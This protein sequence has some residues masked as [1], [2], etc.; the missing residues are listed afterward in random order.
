MLLFFWKAEDKI[1]QDER[2]RYA[3]LR[4]Q[5][6]QYMTQAEQAMIKS[7]EESMAKLI[8]DR[9]KMKTKKESRTNRGM[10]WERKRERVS[11]A[12]HN[13]GKV[14]NDKIDGKAYSRPVQ[15]KGERKE[16]VRARER[17]RASKWQSQ[18]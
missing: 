11:G 13:T 17:K 1:V 2:K 4:A 12:V 5:Y 6:G 9:Y 18:Q 14:S 15:Q 16:K 10:E 8:Q 7:H 3:R